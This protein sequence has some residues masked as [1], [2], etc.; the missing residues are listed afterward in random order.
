MLEL[1]APVAVAAA[2]T[3]AATIAAAVVVVVVVI[4]DDVA[5]LPRLSFGHCD[6]A[7][8]WLVSMGAKQ[9]AK[10]TILPA[11]APK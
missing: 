2:A 9:F 7:S 4:V 11:I 1:V 3:A 6:F 10:P 5:G 8:Q